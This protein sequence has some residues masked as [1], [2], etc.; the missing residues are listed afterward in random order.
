MCI[1]SHEGG[2]VMSLSI[3]KH[4]R[5]FTYKDYLTWNDDERW[6][7]I[8]SV[9][10]NMTPA[11]RRHQEIAGEL[12]R[13]IGNYLADKSC[14]AYI[15]PFD[16]RLPIGDEQDEDTENVV[17]PDVVVVCDISKLDD[18]GCKGS[19]DLIVEVLS[20]TTA[21]KDRNEKFKLYER[22]GVK[23]YWIVDP[24]HVTIEVFSL[25]DGK[26]GH[27]EI[28]SKEDELKVG[29]FDDLTIDIEAVFKDD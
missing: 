17:Q 20:P 24:M 3:G 27:A 9:P 19:P 8:N 18:R 26:Y 11:S 1:G 21:K 16:V 14:R 7:L 10:H 28:Y 25:V 13:R 5:R 22:V 15:A 12:Y 23:E 6:E 29:I 4:E 2:K